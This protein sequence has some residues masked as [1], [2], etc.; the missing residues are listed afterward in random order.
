M[1]RRRKQEEHTNHERWMIPYGDLITLL[2]AL[3]VV[4]YSLSS[5]NEDKYRVLAQSLAAAFSGTPKTFKPI[6]IGNE[7]ALAPAHG[8]PSAKPQEPGV[9]QPIGHIPRPLPIRKPMRD[10]PR[11]KHMQG[12]SKTEAQSPAAK[13]G[14]VA[15]ALGE[16][17]GLKKIAAEVEAAIAPL[18]KRHMV[19]VRDKEYWLEV[20]IKTDILFPSGVATLSRQAVPVLVKLA[21]ILKPFPNAVRIEGYTD[22]V[23]IHT[24]AFPS[25]W[26]LSAARAASVARLLIRHGLDPHRL[27]IIGWGEY[28]PVADNATAAGRNRNRRV[29]LVILGD[30]KVPARFYSD[31]K[32]SDG[33]HI[34]GKGTG[35]KLPDGGTKA[36]QGAAADTAQPEGETNAHL[37]DR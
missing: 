4:M 34:D 31:D 3:F 33:K 1:A 11:H 8:A 12:N 16:L 13:P 29:T 22:N 21:D 27:A 2:L 37:G 26:E 25:N 28:H 9:V 20:E 23:P 17:A 30:S 36:P 32:S 6:E 18:I 35:S 14:A 24:H 15:E 7:T 5:I 19:V 10:P